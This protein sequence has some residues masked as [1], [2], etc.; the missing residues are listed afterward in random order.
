VNL[1]ANYGTA[2]K[3]KAMLL[4]AAAA[5]KADQEMA[6]AQFNKGEGGF[7]NGDLYVFC[8][9]LSDSKVVAGSISTPAG[10]DPV[11]LREP[12]TGRLFGAE[13]VAGLNKPEIN[14]VEYLW[15]K[16]GTTGPAFPKVSY[17]MKVAP[18]LG[19]GVGYYK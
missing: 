15:P 7:R 6:L 8:T 18:N 13:L 16:P 19:C 11:S 10:L 14:T 9:R 4:K 5:V 2:D 12:G 1:G 17:V 3:A